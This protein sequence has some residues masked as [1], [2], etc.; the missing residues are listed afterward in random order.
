MI[1]AAMTLF[2]LFHATRLRTDDNVLTAMRGL[3]QYSM[4]AL[5]V[6]TPLLE[7]YSASPVTV[8]RT[9]HTRNSFDYSR[10]RSGP[11]RPACDP[12]VGEFFGLKV[13]VGEEP[14]ER[15]DGDHTEYD[16]QQAAPF[17]S[18]AAHFGR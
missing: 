7:N 5:I 1:S 4:M 13:P 18:E 16:L 17:R 12:D 10:L 2:Q 14:A 8:N 15:D 6:S 11:E 9:P 3:S